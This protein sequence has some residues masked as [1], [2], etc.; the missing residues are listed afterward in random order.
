MK[1]M[2]LR[3]DAAR[4][5]DMFRKEGGLPL[6]REYL[7]NV[8]GGNLAAVNEALNGGGEGRGAGRTGAGRCLGDWPA[9]ACARPRPRRRS[10]FVGF[11]PC[12]SAPRLCAS[13]TDSQPDPL[14]GQNP[15]N[16]KP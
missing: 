10:C 1:V 15:N 9:A 11:A 7:A 13:R 6:I 5:V 12:G 8:Q 3:L 16:H 14:G 4:T 2:E